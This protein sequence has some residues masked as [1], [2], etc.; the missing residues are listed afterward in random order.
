M[1]KFDASHSKGSDLMLLFCRKKACNIGLYLPV[2]QIR[3]KVNFILL[4]DK[5]SHISKATFNL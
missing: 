3:T 2:W 5:A 1:E 4:S